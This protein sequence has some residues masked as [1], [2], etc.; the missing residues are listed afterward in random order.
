MT[1]IR[2]VLL[3]VIILLQVFVSG[4]AYINAQRDDVDSL[5]TKWLSEQEFDK[6][7]NTLSQVKTTH[8]QF[9]KLMLRKKEINEQISFL[10]YS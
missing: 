9:L 4:C 1:R 6:A 2:L 10:D 3:Q 7:R 8:P 5:I